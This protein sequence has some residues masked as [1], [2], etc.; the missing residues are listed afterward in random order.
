M[1]WHYYKWHCNHGVKSY[2]KYY[3]RFAISACPVD[4]C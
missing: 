1:N 3:E 4:D 2:G